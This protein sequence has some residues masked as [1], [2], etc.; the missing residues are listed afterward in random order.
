MS[1]QE[2]IILEF[3]VSVPE[4]RQTMNIPRKDMPQINSG[5]VADFINFLKKNKIST[6]KMMVDPN[7]LKATQGQF[8]KSKIKDMLDKVDSGSLDD[9][10]IIISKDNYVMDGH[11]RW[12]AFVNLNR[13]M[14]VF[15]VNLNAKELLQKMNEYPKTFNK[16][17]YEWFEFVCERD[18]C[19][20]LT[21]GQMREFEKLVDKMFERFK[22][23]FDFTKHFRER[24]SDERNDPCITLRELA[25]MIRKIYEQNK[26]DGKT[27][28][29]FKDAEAVVKDIQTNLNMP[30]AVEYDRSKDEL[31]VAAKTILRKKDFYTSSKI[32]KI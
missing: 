18:V 8:D 32:I 13:D 14:Q 26:K 20:V 6:T 19:P 15:R 22:I 1:K 31:R 11:H 5:D 17:L 21:V 27:L 10:P 24:M 23:N 28:S 9:K 4:K 7:D 16:K 2:N 29:K 3:D 12:L 25:I 30:I